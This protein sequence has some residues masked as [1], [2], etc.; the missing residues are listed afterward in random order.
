MYALNV[1]I[2]CVQRTQC[3]HRTQYGIYVHLIVQV[4]SA[5]NVYIVYIVNIYIVYGVGS[6]YMI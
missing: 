4:C 6:V 1:Y 2:Q 3:V 5:N